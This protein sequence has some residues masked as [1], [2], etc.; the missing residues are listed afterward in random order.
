[1]LHLLDESLETLLRRK[2][3]IGR[4]DVDIAFD[5]PDNEW[6]GRITKP[7]INLFLWD[8][9]RSVDE[10]ESGRER[11]A[12]GGKDHWRLKPPR[13]AFSYL[14]TAW[15]NEARDEHRLLGSALTTLLAT[16]QIEDEFLAQDLREVMP[17][18]T[19][20]VARPDAK[21]FAEFWSAIDGELK[22]GLD[23]TVT[24]TVDPNLLIEAGPPIAEFGTGL[25]DAADPGQRSTRSRYAGHVDDPNA[26]GVRVTSP[27]GS[28]FVNETG[29][30]WYPPGRAT[31]S[32]C[33]RPSRSPWWPEDDEWRP[34]RQ[35]GS[36][37]RIHLRP[38][39][40]RGGRIGRINR[41]QTAV[42]DRVRGRDP[43]ACDSAC[44]AVVSQE[45]D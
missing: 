9:R 11:V 3:A 39:D 6:S 25:T 36:D 32:R 45:S 21:D 5:A 44:S 38:H 12:R 43:G 17:P 18:P 34:G 1:M 8:V 41:N 16:A 19:L 2:M 10:A 37:E 28:T 14:L 24:A 7:T 4:A 13:I 20:R 29:T 31:P 30:S 35:M 27:R 40:R 22:P 33:T 15:T 26:G 23:I 42:V